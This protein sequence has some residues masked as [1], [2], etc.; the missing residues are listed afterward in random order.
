VDG[1]L[2][3]IGMDQPFFRRREGGADRSP[4]LLR[5]VHKTVQH[6]LQIRLTSPRLE[7]IPH[8]LGRHAV[9]LVP[10]DLFIIEERRGHDDAERSTNRSLE[11]GCVPV[12]SFYE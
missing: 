12:Q 6:D 7:V 11:L 3:H 9:P 5:E 2:H 4:W 10:I 8:S 1:K